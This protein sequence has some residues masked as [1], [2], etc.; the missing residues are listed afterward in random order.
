[1]LRHTGF[2]RKRE[3]A[4]PPF[5]S[6]PSRAWWH[7]SAVILVVLAAVGCESNSSRAEPAPQPEA[8]VAAPGEADERP[9]VAVLGDSL[10][11]GLGLPREQAFPAV[12]QRV[13]DRSGYQVEVVAAGVSGDTSAG[14]LRRLDWVLDDRVSVLVV[15][16]GGNDA[17]RGLSAAA[18][19]DNLRAIIERAHAADVAV[20]LCGMEAPPN[21]GTPFTAE[22]RGVFRSLAEEYRV[23]FVPFLLDGVAGVPALN[24]GDGIHPNAEGARRVA[25]NVW[26]GLEPLLAATLGS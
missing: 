11:A 13:A 14:G 25:D 2:D 3:D 1:M 19:E 9:V 22:F 26:A 12:L 21:F 8:G 6:D 24:Q 15:A 7:L 10:T 23:P 20:L 5:R 17:L 18:M 16:L 4:L